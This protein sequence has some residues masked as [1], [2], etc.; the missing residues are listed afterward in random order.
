[1]VRSTLVSTSEPLITS[2][3][4]DHRELEPDITKATG[5]SVFLL[6]LQ[7]FVVEIHAFFVL[8]ILVKIGTLYI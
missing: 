1:M 5:A 3:K 4:L 7:E 2:P 8:E 6:Q